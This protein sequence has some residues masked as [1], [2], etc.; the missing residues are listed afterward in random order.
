MRLKLSLLFSFLICFGC[1]KAVGPEPADGFEYF[2][3]GSFFGECLGYCQTEIKIEKE[4]VKQK[5]TGWN[6]E[7]E[8]PIIERTEVI[9]QS[10]FEELTKYL[11]FNKFKKLNEVLGCP[12]CKDGGGEWVEIKRNG[13]TYKITFEYG[14]E[15]KELSKT[16]RLLRAYTV[17]FKTGTGQL[18]NFND[19]VLINES[20]KIKNFLCTRGCSQYLIQLDNHSSNDFYFIKYP[21]VAFFENDLPLS[22]HAVIMMDSTAIS[23]PSPTDQPIFDFNAPNIQ[24]FDVKAN[25]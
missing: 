7:G 25:E 15:P 4:L 21:E 16:I 11:D 13:R 24:L 10:Y 17:A 6:L 8:L 14:N 9:N 18:V 23:K 12:D 19:R 2:S 20:G 3:Y 1:N 22:F 5:A